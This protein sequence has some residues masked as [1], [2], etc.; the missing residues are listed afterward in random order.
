[1]PFLKICVFCEV[2]FFEMIKNFMSPKIWVSVYM[3]DRM[4]YTTVFLLIIGLLRKPE[5]F[6]DKGL[7]QGLH[8]L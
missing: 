3:N 4:Q 5:F 7:A 2:F 8:N 1:M 6:S